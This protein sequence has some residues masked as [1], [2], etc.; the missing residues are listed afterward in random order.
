M[1]VLYMMM[2]GFDQSTPVHVEKI[3]VFRSRDICIIGAKEYAELVTPD[4]RLKLKQLPVWIEPWEIDDEGKFWYEE[5]IMR[6]R[7]GCVYIGNHRK[8]LR[9]VSTIMEQLG[10][11]NG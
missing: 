9:D 1:W 10:T 7:Y 2:L 3:N 6:V 4:P 8:I 11:I 5:D